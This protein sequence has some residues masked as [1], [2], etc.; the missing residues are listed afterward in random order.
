M[1]GK[2]AEN[3]A[4]APTTD[5]LLDELLPRARLPRAVGARRLSG[6]ALAHRILHALVWARSETVDGHC[7]AS[8][9][10][11]AHRGSV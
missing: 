6:R 8:I 9:R 2:M 1:V 3:G 11:L 5:D 10:T 4:A 7:K